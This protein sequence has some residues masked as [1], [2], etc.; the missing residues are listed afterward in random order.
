MLAARKYVDEKLDVNIPVYLTTEE[1]V[2]FQQ[3]DR[4]YICGKSGFQPYID[5]SLN[6][7]ALAKVRDHDHFT[8]RFRGPPH[9]QCS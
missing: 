7:P 5:R 4:C 8:E 9:S 2:S 6:P 3:A 1:V